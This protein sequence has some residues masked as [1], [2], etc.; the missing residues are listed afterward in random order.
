M[1]GYLLTIVWLV[2][3]ASSITVAI[4]L[5]HYYLIIMPVACFCGM[6]VSFVQTGS[7]ATDLLIQFAVAVVGYFVL[8]IPYKIG[9]KFKPYKIK[10]GKTNLKALVGE[11]CLV[12]EDIS[13]I[14][15]KGLVNLKGSIWSARS[16][17]PN[18]YVEQGTIVVVKTI[19]G[20]KLVVAREK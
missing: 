14:H 10:K 9:S 4:M 2:L 8:L 3:L 5:Q 15:A 7:M 13:N 11:R 17:D 12:V 6:I 1:G 18:D 20:V 19:E 16:A